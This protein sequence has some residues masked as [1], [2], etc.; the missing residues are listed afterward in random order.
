MRPPHRTVLE[1]G[2]DGDRRP[3]LELLAAVGRAAPEEERFAFVH[4]GEGAIGW[5]VALRLEVPTG[6]GRMEAV[7]AAL[8]EALPADDADPIAFASFTFDPD[9]PGSVV[10]V[11]RTT[12]VRREGRSVLTT[13]GDDPVQDLAAAA[14]LTAAAADPAAAVAPADRPRYAGSTLRDDRWLESVAGGLAAIAEGRLEK[15]VLARDL[16]V[17]SRTP[18]DVDAILAVLAERFPSCFTFLVD[19]LL[20]ASPELLLARQGRAVRSRVLAGTAPRGTDTAADAALGEA[21]LASE[22]ERWEHDLARSSVVEALAPVCAALDAPTVPSLVRLENVQHL[23]TDLVGSL[24][25][26]THVLSLL[27]RLHPTAAVAGTPRDTALATIRTL[28]GMSRGRY[29]GPVGWLSPSGDGEFAIALRCGAFDGTRA[30]LF[31][32]VGIVEGSLP[33][34]ELAETWL[35]LRAMMGALGDDTTAREVTDR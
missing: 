18:F 14:A 27:E 33:E 20:G 35:K 29:A 17:W 2:T 8:S 4:D 1:A 10:V 16:Q 15:V 19:G 30:R 21:L 12:L 24:S 34:L 5:G 25:D 11:P 3:L 26:D 32:G 22:K 7:R 9:E 31:A 13:V 23:G 6:P 28:E